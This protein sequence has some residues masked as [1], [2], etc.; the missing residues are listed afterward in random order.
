MNKGRQL[1]R[2]PTILQNENAALRNKVKSLEEALEAA[3]KVVGKVEKVLP[4]IISLAE[5]N[6][7]LK[8][9]ND[10]FRII[11]YHY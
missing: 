10:Q 9:E 2:T 7:K 3:Y 8:K 4:N 11:Q 1:P 6:E 5:E